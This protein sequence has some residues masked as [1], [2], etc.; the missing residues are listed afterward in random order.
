LVRR[1]AVA[2]ELVDLTLCQHLCMGGGINE[3]LPR[4]IDTRFVAQSKKAALFGRAKPGA[5]TFGPPVIKALERSVRAAYFLAKAAPNSD[6]NRHFPDKFEIDFDN[7]GHL[8]PIFELQNSRRRRM[9][10]KLPATRPQQL[11]TN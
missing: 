6:V 9:F 4:N 10:P 2:A 8:R 7:L 1:G 3:R 5:L 11:G